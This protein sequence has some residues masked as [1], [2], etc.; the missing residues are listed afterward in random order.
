MFE[1]NGC[2]TK[3]HR[4]NP[5][6]ERQMWYNGDEAQNEGVGPYLTN[7]CVP[8]PSPFFSDLKWEDV[9][10]WCSVNV[11]L[12]EVLHRSKNIKT[13]E[14]QI[15]KRTWDK[16]LINVIANKCLFGDPSI[17]QKTYSRYLVSV[18]RPMI[19]KS[20]IFAF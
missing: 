20:I 15:N 13:A 19:W 2:S 3:Q 1:P 6:Q 8:P 18:F 10:L 9:L 7:T 17:H 11:C 12:R 14:K 16:T 4:T 5:C